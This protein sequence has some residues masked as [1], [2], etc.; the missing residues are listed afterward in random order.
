[1]GL[2]YYTGD[3]L[4]DAGLYWRDGT[5]N[6]IDFTSGYTFSLKVYDH[7]GTTVLFTKTT[8]ITGATGSLTVPTPN[9]VIAWSTTLELTTITT[10]GDYQLRL[11]A[12]RTADGKTRTFPTTLRILATAA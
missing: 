7:D 6:L 4:G 5:G 11:T 3:E 10:A 2:E 12:T 8:G 1:M 9:V